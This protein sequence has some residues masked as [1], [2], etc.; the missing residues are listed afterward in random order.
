MDEP[1]GPG[2]GGRIGSV[3]L[4]LVAVA[5]VLAPAALRL[6]SATQVSPVYS[7]LAAQF[8]D[9]VEV[10]LM[11][12]T[13]VGWVIFGCSL[14]LSGLGGGVIGGLLLAGGIIGVI[15]QAFFPGG[16]DLYGFL[17]LM[18]SNGLTLGAALVFTGIGAHV[19]RQAGFKR[20]V[21]LA[22]GRTR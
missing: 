19:A 14:M 8:G 13:V 20:A 4:T 12:V 16:A 6:L 1:G 5:F 3:V 7:D 15:L 17:I 11:I 9:L 21:R 10:G 18:A 2:V 22:Q